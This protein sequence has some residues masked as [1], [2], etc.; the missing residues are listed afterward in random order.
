MSMPKRLLSV[1]CTLALLFTMMPVSAFAQTSNTPGIR[2]DVTSDN[3]STYVKAGD[4]LTM[5]VSVVNAADTAGLLGGKF[6]VEFDTA[7]LTAVKQSMVRGDILNT[8][9]PDDEKC[10]SIMVNDAAGENQN[11]VGMV[12]KPSDEAYNYTGDVT[13]KFSDGATLLFTYQLKV[14]D[15]LPENV[16][17][18]QLPIV[19]VSPDMSLG[20][21]AQPGN[22]TSVTP[23]TIY[24]DTLPMDTV[25]PVISI[26]DG[27]SFFYQPVSFTVTD[28]NGL[29]SVALNGTALYAESDGTFLITEGGE[30]TAT[31]TFG[32]VARVNFTLDASLFNKAKDAVAAIPDE[33]NY[34]HKDIVKKA[35]DAL[36]NVTNGEARDHLANEE[37]RANAAKLVLDAIDTEINSLNTLMG[38]L[39]ATMTNEALDNLAQAKAKLVELQAKGVTTDDL[40]AA[41]YAHFQSV[42][43]ELGALA[44][45]VNQFKTALA[46]LYARVDSFTYDDV[47]ALE[48]LKDAS[49][50]LQSK[51]YVLP[52]DCSNQLRAIENA[53]TTLETNRAA[54]VQEV[55]NADLTADFTVVNRDKIQELR[56]KVDTFASTYKKAFM[57]DELSVLTTAEQNVAALDERYATLKNKLADLP[58][59]DSVKLTQEEAL[60][61]IQTEF[62]ALTKL[63]AEFTQDEKDALQEAFTGIQDIRDQIAAVDAEIEAKKDLTPATPEAIAQYVALNNE[64]NALL[65]RGVE[66][67][68]LSNYADFE[69]LKNVFS[70]AMGEVD[71]VL[72]KIAELP[73]ASAVDFTSEEKITEVGNV[74]AALRQTY[75]ENILTASQLQP[76]TE[77]KEALG[78]LKDQRTDLV[79]RIAAGFVIKLDTAS[80]T[81]I[82]D[83][84]NSVTELNGKGAA[85]T[86]QELKKLVKAEADLKALQ[87]ESKNLHAAINAL[88]SADMVNYSDKQK[89]ADLKS[90]MQQFENDK[91]DTFTD[92]EKQKITAVETEI[93]RLEQ[94]RADLVT[95]M[96]SVKD[97]SLDAVVYADK[98]TAD[99]LKAREDALNARGLMLDETLANVARYRA[100]AAA[101]ADMQT[102]VAAA[103]T[104]MDAALANWSY[105]QDQT[106]Y[107]QIRIKMD[108]LKTQYEMPQDVAVALFVNYNTSVEKFNAAKQQEAAIRK[109]IA[110]LP[111]ATIENEASFKDVQARLTAFAQENNLSEANLV[112]LF[113]EAYQTVKKGISTIDTLKREAMNAGDQHPEIAE[114]IAN[115]TWGKDTSSTPA[116]AQ[117]AAKQPVRIPQTSDDFPYGLM[118]LLIGVGLI[119]M[120]FVACKKKR[121]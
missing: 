64:V 107:D 54:L 12:V 104:E 9:L 26:A 84:R 27:A 86:E 121:L 19:I 90:K 66:T 62:D 72:A 100:F 29:Q 74:I 14:A 114:A 8:K 118:V 99:S 98:E 6:L 15:T 41:S 63:Q 71:A 119:G 58:S 16:S 82:T 10:F 34:S 35:L 1:L 89:A 48:K 76:Y 21:N 91:G 40:D 3:G 65:D 102:K 32:N 60:N 106:I 111:K 116:A 78:A 110:R 43:E 93:A 83:T 46:D 39:T 57:A 59:R 75:G 17:L 109:Q 49:A 80:K 94:L 105:I 50:Y 85:F 87:I 77:A 117:P 33:V 92:A 38:S 11:K 96:G 47:E 5:R 88:P 37:A 20:I 81:A 103:N 36:G 31:D 67:S 56:N 22:L 101:V 112:S 115:G 2:L 42:D 73:A 25:K 24:G 45:K 52:T 28:N 18:D 7:V 55:S 53:Y 51:G 30:I 23:D 120:A 108:A 79:E 44:E 68:D 70:A 95:D 69:A 61:E 4:T 97:V 113:G 13:P